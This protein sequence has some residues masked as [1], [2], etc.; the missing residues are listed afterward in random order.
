MHVIGFLGG[1]HAHYDWYQ[2]KIKGYQMPVAYTVEEL[3]TLLIDRK[4]LAA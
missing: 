1:A 3:R 2:E 4:N